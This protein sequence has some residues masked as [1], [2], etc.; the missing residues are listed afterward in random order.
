MEESKVKLHFVPVGGDVPALSKPKFKYSGNKKLYQVNEKLKQ[1]LNI[2]PNLQLYFYCGNAF[3]PTP[4]Q[5]LQEL[6]DCFGID[7]E[8]V[9]QYG[10]KEVW[11]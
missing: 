3:S 5:V 10:I 2:N 4:D 6:Y 11:G 1:L 9:L 8:L 7:G